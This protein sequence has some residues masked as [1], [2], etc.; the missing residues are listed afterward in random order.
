VAQ[1]QHTLFILLIG[2][3]VID[4]LFVIIELCFAIGVTAETLRANIDLKLL[5]MK[6]G[7]DLG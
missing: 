2:K 1:T 4:L 3:P 7:V 5:F 6:D